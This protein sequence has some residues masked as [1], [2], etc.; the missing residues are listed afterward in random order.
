MDLRGG[1]ETK[2]RRKRI[3]KILYTSPNRVELSNKCS[4]VVGGTQ[5]GKTKCF[6][7]VER[8]ET[9]RQ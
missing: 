1:G 5:G 2:G 8:W 9:L 6:Q 7:S 3:L 4:G